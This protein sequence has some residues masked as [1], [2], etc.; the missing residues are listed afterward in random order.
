MKKAIYLAGLLVLTTACSTPEITSK[1]T[2]DQPIPVEVADVKKIELS[3][4]LEL[5]GQAIPG[6]TIPLIAPSPLEIKE[7][8][9]KVGSTVEKGD[10]IASLDDTAARR[11]VAN[12]SNAV[13]ELEKAVTQAKQLSSEAEKNA[14]EL[15]AMQEELNSSLQR[16]QTLLKQIDTE[17]VSTSDVLKE[18]LEVAIKQAELSQAAASMPSMSAGNVTQLES[19]LAETK[20]S[21]NQ[22]RDVL[23]ATTIEAP[24]TGVISQINAEENSTAVPNSPIAVVVNMDPVVASF[25]VNS[26]QISKLSKGQKVKI[27]FDGIDGMFSGELSEIPPTANEQTGSFVIDIELENKENKIKG[28]MKATARIKTD[29]IKDAI[30]VPKESIVYGEKETYVFVSQG[31]KVKKVPVKV[32]AE[33]NE[34]IQITDG[35]TTKDDVVTN[36]KDRLS[37]TSE[38]QVQN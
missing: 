19:Q 23:N 5:T 8:N 21:L 36:G 27:S 20:A 7:L 31:K 32:G 4:E 35:L 11:N 26:F 3:D 9:V 14:Q 13:D 34:T 10:L 16:S 37:E 15:K 28:G 38:I 2:N 25:Q 29:V 6:T 30:V 12:L 22:A 1:E 17:D 24:I 33:S 18:S